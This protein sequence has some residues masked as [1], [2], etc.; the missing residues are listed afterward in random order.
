MFPICRSLTGEGNRKTLQILK[1][2]L[3]NLELKTI[4][5]GT[6]VFDWQV[7]K[8][9]KINDAYVKDSSGK[10]IIDFK[11]SNL[12]VMSYSIPIN[13]KMNLS[14][15]KKHLITIKI[16][17]IYFSFMSDISLIHFPFI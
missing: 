1:D 11:D 7:P 10:K 16:P 12:H 4:K 6:D 3:P 15:L 17:S 2:E 5:S 14:E 9:W 13:K 8:E